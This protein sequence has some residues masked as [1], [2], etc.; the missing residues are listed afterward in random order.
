MPQTPGNLTEFHEQS[1]SAPD[2]GNEVFDM[3]SSNELG[4]EVESQ[5]HEK[6]QDPPVLPECEYTSILS[7]GISQNL[8]LCHSLTS[9]QPPR[10][11][12]PNFKS[13]WKEKTVE[14]CSPAED[15]GQDDVIFSGKVKIIS[16]EQF[17]SK[18]SQAIPRL[19]KMQNDSKISDYVRQ[20]IAEA[21]SL[22]KR[23]LNH[24]SIT[25]SPQKC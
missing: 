18:I 2:S 13:Y 6:N 5:S 3:V 10:S 4:I 17:F 24:K 20:N 8:L 14:P 1:T 19:E 25:I 15:A 7:I 12:K 11:Q 9:S 23:D 16:K 22:L 21:M